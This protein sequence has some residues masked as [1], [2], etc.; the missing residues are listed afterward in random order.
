[1][2]SSE[3]PNLR[4]HICNVELLLKRGL[5]IPPGKYQLGTMLM[6]PNRAERAVHGCLIPAQVI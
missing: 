6:R 3:V 1:M 5:Q 4:Y 2:N